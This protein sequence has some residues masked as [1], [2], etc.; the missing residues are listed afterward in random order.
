MRKF[1]SIC[2]VNLFL[3]Y[4]PIQ[5]ILEI[6]LSH[7]TQAM[8]HDYINYALIA[9]VVSI[10]PFLALRAAYNRIGRRWR[11]LESDKKNK[12]LSGKIEMIE[13]EE[14]DLENQHLGREINKC[15]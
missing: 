13:E 9:Y 6:I 12:D 7:S 15:I 8:K 4:L 14:G 3:I 11:R 10:F 2:F 5:Y 1:I